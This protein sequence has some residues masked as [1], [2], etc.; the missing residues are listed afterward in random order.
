[1]RFPCEQKAINRMLKD[2]KEYGY[3]NFISCLQEAWANDLNEAYPDHP[4]IGEGQ[5]TWGDVDNMHLR[6]RELEAENAELKQQLEAAICCGSCEH[7]GFDRDTGLCH[8]NKLNCGT[9]RSFTDEKLQQCWTPIIR[10]VQ[11]QEAQHDH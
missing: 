6:I 11:L 4:G 10:D 3:G 7:L 1:M 9:Y 8:C 5:R 2:A